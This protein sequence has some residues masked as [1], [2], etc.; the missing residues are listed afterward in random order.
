MKSL[1][2]I[3]ITFPGNRRFI[4]IKEEFYK[5]AAFPNVIGTVD[6]THIRIQRSGAHEGDYAGNP[7]TVSMF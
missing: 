6:C 7:S 1:V 3:F 4:H 2:H 5:I